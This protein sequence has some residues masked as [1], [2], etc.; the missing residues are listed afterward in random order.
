MSRKGR[1]IKN[2]K[3][4]SIYANYPINNII[5]GNYGNRRVSYNKLWP[6][7][8]RVAVPDT[9]MSTVGFIP[10]YCTIGLGLVAPTDNG[11]SFNT[12]CDLLYQKL[13]AV[14]T[15]SIT[16]TTDDIKAYVLNVRSLHAYVTTLQRIW[17]AMNTVNQYDV[18]SPD[19]LVLALTG[20]NRSHW[21]PYTASLMTAGNTLATS[22]RINFPLNCDL[23][24]R[25]NNLL[26]NMFADCDDSSAS[27]YLFYVNSFPYYSKEG[28]K[29]K[30]E[31]Y[32]KNPSQVIDEMYSVPA[33]IGSALPTTQAIAGDM[34]RAFGAD[35]YASKWEFTFG[36]TIPSIYNEE[37]LM[38]ICNAEIN[39]PTY[40]NN[41]FECYASSTN[42]HMASVTP[43]GKL[44]W[45]VFP[46]YGAYAPSHL[47]NWCYDSMSGE[48]QIGVTRLKSMAIPTDADAET[49][50]TETGVAFT[51]KKYK[52]RSGFEVVTGF[53]LITPTEL[54]AAV[55]AVP[56]FTNVKLGHD[57]S[58]AFDDTDNQYVEAGVAAMD[59]FPIRYH[60]QEL[61]R[62][63]TS[64]TLAIAKQILPVVNYDVWGVIT[65][66][67]L[68]NYNHYAVLSLQIGRAHV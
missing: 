16:Y 54:G 29:G 18:N 49:V 23:L 37:I 66:N 3:T 38:E 12:A 40:I 27:H 62:S 42:A 31:I 1:K 5:T 47:V 45:I 68:D 56:P 26:G 4:D 59:Y 48:E 50:T 64:V 9:A 25:T 34:L 30:Y 43:A 51:I 6:L 39:V 58:N 20:V 57:T 36:S 61:R 22:V 24:T 65:N 55:Y 8:S 15:S 7:D 19:D 13:R 53:N 11:N 2:A 67:D 60:A 46:A 33:T 28:F 44:D 17:A 32:G 52:I 41:S 35:A 21:T 63:D 14:S 10:S